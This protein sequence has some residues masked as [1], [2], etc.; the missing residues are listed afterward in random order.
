[1]LFIPVND[2]LLLRGASI[3]RLSIPLS[4]PVMSF[5]VTLGS[6]EEDSFSIVSRPNP[7]SRML[8][9]PRGVRPSLGAYV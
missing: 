1:M 8:G 5:G 7:C 3:R 2:E 4:S 9:G 6:F